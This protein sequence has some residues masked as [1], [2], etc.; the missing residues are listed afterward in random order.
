MFDLLLCF[1][2]SLAETDHEVGIVPLKARKGLVY[3]SDLNDRNSSERGQHTHRVEVVSGTITH[4]DRPDEDFCECRKRS[5]Q[6]HRH[7]R[8]SRGDGHDAETG[9]E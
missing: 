5:R 7:K 3:L 6:Y 9:G 4:E 2:E 1:H 8:V